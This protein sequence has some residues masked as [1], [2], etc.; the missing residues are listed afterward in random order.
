MK[1]RARDDGQD[2]DSAPEE[3]VGVVASFHG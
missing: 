1:W 3:A 2:R